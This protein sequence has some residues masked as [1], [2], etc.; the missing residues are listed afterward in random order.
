M[1]REKIRLILEEAGSASPRDAWCET[2]KQLLEERSSHDVK[3]SKKGKLFEAFTLEWIARNAT[4]SPQ[5]SVRIE[6]NLWD[7]L[8]EE[9]R[10]GVLAERVWLSGNLRAPVIVESRVDLAALKWST[11]EVERVVAAYSCKASIRERYQQDLF[12]ADRL[13][14]RG[15]RFCLITDDE[16]LRKYA[17][18]ARQSGEAPKAVRLACAI[19]DRVYLL[20]EQLSSG[21]PVF[22]PITKAWQD[23]VI[24]A[25]ME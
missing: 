17:L 15:I 1:I 18:K 12:W 3:R 24:W 23:L 5:G 7:E 11:S 2:L 13:K 21:Q 6:L 25:S 4:Q 8:P 22:Q 10:K 20:D 16:D 9:L 14:A 19:Y